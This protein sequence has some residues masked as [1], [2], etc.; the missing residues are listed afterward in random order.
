MNT[1]V[2][3]D[4]YDV[5]D[6]GLAEAGGRRVEWAGRFRPVLRSIRERFER[7]KPFDGVR[8]SACLHVT[9][10]T[11]NLMHAL[12]AGGADVVLCASNP[13]ST[14]DDVAAWLVEELV[15]GVFAIKGEDD[16]TYYEHIR[17]A[18]AHRPAVTMDDGADLVGAL[19]MMALGRLEVFAVLVL[20]MPRFWKG[21]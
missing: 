19:H 17:A 16:E 13:L 7:E 20:F 21:D 10:E 14:Q 18:L 11:A 3:V 1:S 12:K 4:R 2:D 9:S 15:V 5:K 6:L 8:V